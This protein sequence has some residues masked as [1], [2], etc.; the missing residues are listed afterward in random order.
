MTINPRQLLD[1]YE[2]ARAF[3]QTRQD[4]LT[5][6]KPVE[7]LFE[8]KKRTADAVVM[9]YGVYNAGKSTLINALIGREDAATGDI[10]LTDKVSA[11]A[12]GA[13]SI[14]DT[15]GVDAPIE[16]ERVTREHMLKADAVI[17]VVD[18]V[19]TAE[20]IKTLQVLLDLVYEGKQ[21]FMVFNEKKAVPDDDYITLKDRTRARL[22]AMAAESGRANVLENIP[23]AKVNARRAL[24]GRL[25]GQ[26]KL[27]ELSGFPAF[28]GQLLAFLQGITQ[29]EIY[30]RLKQLLTSFLSAYVDILHS[31]TQSGVAQKY[32]KLLRVVS[33][34][35]SRLAQCMGRELRQQRQ[36]IYG[37]CK[38]YMRSAEEN[39]QPKLELLLQRSGE[40]AGLSL[41]HEMKAFMALVEEEIEAVQ[42]AMPRVD[43]HAVPVQVPELDRATAATG[44]SL[45]KADS[46]VDTAALK[47]VAQQ[48][49]AL[50]K[51]E[52]IVSGLK[53]VKEALPSLMKG[54]GTKTMEKWA[55]ALASKWI[56]Y[57]G[58]GISAAQALYGLFAGDPEAERLHKENQEQAR[59][60]ERVHQQIEDFALEISSGYEASMQEIVQKQIDVF[61]GNV[62]EQ[63]ELLRHAFN[64]TEQA[65]TRQLEQL[66]AIQQYAQYA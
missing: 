3:V 49:G 18:P 1:A 52:H 23:M 36:D 32:D 22:Q 29:D 55:G 12:W 35:K 62:A 61:F 19:G 57:V 5:E 25:K 34:E 2:Q 24:H 47:D 28:E 54:I 26:T 41:E 17:F 40:Q 16:H 59:A 45:P 9:I 15:P 44:G 43:H 50:A 33:L 65:Q 8:D 7:Q 6:F 42:A 46:S 13:Y 48:L 20:E 51:P 31:H 58:I 56:P 39:C 37:K 21:V 63:V 4:R 64:E 53:L 60:R 10:P 30:G 14:L 66:L 38:V 11:Y 27:V